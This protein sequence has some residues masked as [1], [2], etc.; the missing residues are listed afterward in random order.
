MVILSPLL[1]HFASTLIIKVSS[2]ISGSRSPFEEASSLESQSSDEEELDDPTF[3]QVQHSNMGTELEQLML[4]IE[5]IIANLF[6]L[7]TMIR[8]GNVH[9]DRFE[10]SS[11][12][13]V[14]YYEPYDIQH[15]MTKFPEANETLMNR[16]GKANSRRRQY[17]K[18]RE[19]HHEMLAKPSTAMEYDSEHREGV[20]R[21]VSVVPSTEASTFMA[22]KFPEP[23]NLEVEENSVADTN[24]S[25]AT[26]ISNEEQLR[27]PPPPETARDGLDFE[28][29]Y[30]FNICRFI[31]SEEWQRRREWK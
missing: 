7:S 17:L 11:K 12:I 19:T 3:G 22:D 31:G 4:G 9:H 29:P 30:C 18:Y 5:R 10:K 2:I 26:S 20:D 16:M 27:V 24:T 21:P 8:K 14:S 15:T 23:F 6:K 13:D 25:Y 1:L 28:C